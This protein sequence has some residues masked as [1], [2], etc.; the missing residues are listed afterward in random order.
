MNIL[1]TLGRMPKGLDLARGFSNNDCQVF[2][3]DP[4]KNH[5]SRY[6][7]SITECRAVT[8]PNISADAFIQDLLEIVTDKSIDMVVPVSEESVYASLMKDRLPNNVSFFGPA[9]DTACMLHDKFRFNQ[10]LHEQGFPAPACALL[11]D[12]AAEDLIT[13]FDA[14]IKPVHASAGIDIQYLNKGDNLPG[15]TNR[16]AMIQQRMFGRLLTSLSLAKKGECL[17]T[18]I[19]EG[20]IFSGSVATAFKRVDNIQAVNDFVDR[21]IENLNYSG[22]ISFDLFL[23]EDGIAY[24]IECNPRLTSGIHLFETTDIAKAILEEEITTSIRFRQRDSFQHFWPCLGITEMS[25]I[26]GGPFRHN[27]RHFLHSAD[28]T[29]SNN[30]PLPFLMMNFCSMEIFKKYF[31]EKMSLGEAAITDVEWR[32]DSQININ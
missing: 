8:A 21:F 9:F 23:N 15:T 11:G 32:G 22:F 17:A 5:I 7:N 30:D 14:V 20:S 18:G 27:L 26:N 28:V 3:A 10:Y 16:P 19:Y 2:V 6:S 24:A 31:L 4:H 12:N 1:L 29:W 25:L 13:N